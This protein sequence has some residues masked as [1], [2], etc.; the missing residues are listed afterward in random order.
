[1]S[2]ASNWALHCGKVK[3][4]SFSLIVV[5]ALIVMMGEVGDSVDDEGWVVMLQEADKEG[6]KDEY[7]L[8]CFL[9]W[10]HNKP[11]TAL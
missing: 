10:Y 6:K 8:E 1:M 3:G 11:Y 4:M 5:A 2:K 9:L 7:S